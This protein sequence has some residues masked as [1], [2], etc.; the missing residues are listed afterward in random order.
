[1]FVLTLR[2]LVEFSCLGI[3]ILAAVA[4]SI[5]MAWDNRKN[6]KD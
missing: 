4:M 2:D 3:I 1:M 6:K 5:S